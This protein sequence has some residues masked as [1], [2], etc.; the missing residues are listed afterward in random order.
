ME[1]VFTLT[2][3]KKEQIDEC[4]KFVLENKIDEI[5]CSL[6][7]LSN[8]DLNRF[9]DFTDNNLKILKFLPDNKEIL[10]RNLIFDYYDYIP[11]ISLRNIPLDEV[12]NKII[13][14][15]FDIVFSLLIIVGI[16]S[17]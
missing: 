12:A 9:I 4:F 15:I 3:N 6:S 16:L 5:Y 7:D 1:K 8:A 10:A 17:G 13:K 14:R 2:P 11:I